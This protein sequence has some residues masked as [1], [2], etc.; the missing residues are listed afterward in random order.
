MRVGTETP[1]L[2]APFP[3][4]W[5]RGLKKRSRLALL[6]TV[7]ELSDMAAPAITGLSSQPA[8]APADAGAAAA[9]R[10]SLDE[11]T[12]AKVDELKQQGNAAIK[13]KDFGAAVASYSAAIELDSFNCVLFGNRAAAKLKLQRF[14]EALADAQALRDAQAGGDEQLTLLNDQL[15]T[16]EAELVELQQSS[17]TTSEQLMEAQAKAT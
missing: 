8:P 1:C 16:A 13:A 9:E 5:P 4:P 17:A 7:T 11:E 10:P 15:K 2:A 6:T 12:L 3:L 14:E